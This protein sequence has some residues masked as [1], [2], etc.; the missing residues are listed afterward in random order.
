MRYV[1]HATDL[2]G[3]ALAAYE[4]ESGCDDDATRRAEIFLEAHPSIEIW[5]GVR[6]V[7]RL[8][9]A[10][11]EIRQQLAEAHQVEVTDNEVKPRQKV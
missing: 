6:R 5:D 4:I 7:A 3:V 11:A 9:R 8:T 1:V 2:S 10:E